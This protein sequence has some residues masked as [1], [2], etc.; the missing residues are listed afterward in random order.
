MSTL[1][2]SPATR[3][4]RVKRYPFTLSDAAKSAVPS[5]AG[6]TGFG[7]PGPIRPRLLVGAETTAPVGSGTS[8]SRGAA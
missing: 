3:A 6:A 2:L 8:P 4:A 7:V 1:D 5:P